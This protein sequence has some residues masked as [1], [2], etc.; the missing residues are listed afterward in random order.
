MPPSLELD[1]HPPAATRDLRTPTALPPT[2]L[3][4][5]GKSPL[6]H[7]QKSTAVVPPRA[8]PP[9]MATTLSSGGAAELPI[10][11]QSVR[12]PRRPPTTSRPEPPLPRSES[13]SRAEASRPHRRSSQRS[14]SGATAAPATTTTTA[15][16]SSRH[17]HHPSQQQGHHHQQPDMSAAA[18][19][20]APHGHASAGDEHRTGA[21]AGT[22]TH[23]SATGTT[24]QRYRTVIPAPSGNYAFIKT[25]GQGSMG[26]VKL[27]KKEGTN[28]L[29]SPA[30]KCYIPV[31]PFL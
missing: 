7:T 13:T 15:T 30:V 24:K 3:H 12:T 26:K 9:P 19:A 10:R 31:I 14:A 18:A 6:L 8:S 1:C 4:H 5:P 25:I 23:R 21:D 28:E 27:A 17:H 11:S 29:V 16:S 20:A 22:S 2:R